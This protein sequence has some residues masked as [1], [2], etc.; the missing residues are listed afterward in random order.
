[1]KTINLRDFYKWYTHD[2]FVEVSDE[3]AEEMMAD[4]RYQRSHERR[5]RY[6]NTYAFDDITEAEAA[7]IAH[8]TDN[9]EAILEIKERFCRLCRALNSLPEIQGR[10]IEARYIHGKSIT[11]IAEDEGVS[12]SSVSISV[13]RG[14]EAMKKYL[15]NPD[16]QSNKCPN[17]LL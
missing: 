13:T 7:T 8:T 12:K 9:P 16:F 5:M 2:E 1:M 3:V 6:N 4:K 10:R 14:L 15:E 17:H 11:E